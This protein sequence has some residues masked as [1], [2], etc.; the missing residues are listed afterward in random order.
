MPASEPLPPY[1]R[2]APLRYIATL[3]GARA[4]QADIIDIAPLRAHTPATRPRVCAR[5]LGGWRKA[6]AVML[7]LASAL[8]LGSVNATLPGVSASSGRIGGVWAEAEAGAGEGDRPVSI[9]LHA[10][11][12]KPLVYTVI[13]IV[14]ANLCSEDGTLC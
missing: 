13:F 11:Y 12:D 5:G 9:L 1:P 10:A 2:S 3:L 14:G 7:V 4:V 8:S 6:G